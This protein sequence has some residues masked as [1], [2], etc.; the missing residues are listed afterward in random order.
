VTGEESGL[1]GSEYYSKHPLFPLDKTVVNLNMDGYGNKGRTRDVILGASGDSETDA[2]VVEAA[3][4]QGRIVRPSVNQ[5]S[6]GYYRSDHFNFAKVGVPVVLAKGGRDY[7]NPTA[8]E[9]KKVK[10]GNKSTYHQPSDEYHSWW[11]V[12]GSLDDIYLLYGIGLRLAN[13][14]YFPKWN[15]GVVYKE[16]REGKR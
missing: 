10:Y 7:L 5:T 1:L 3:A 15:D 12:S 6:G 16:I 9:E 4:T 11:D 13:D 8:E 2:Y 14:G